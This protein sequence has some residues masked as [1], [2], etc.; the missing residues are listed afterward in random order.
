MNLYACLE[1]SV[2]VK[3]N[4]TVKIPIGFALEIPNGYVGLIF[5]RSGLVTNKGLAPAN[6]V[7]VCDSLL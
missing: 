1:E 6:K 5:A 2:V 4:E 7:G 3:P